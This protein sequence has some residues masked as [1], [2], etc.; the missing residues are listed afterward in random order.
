M[1]LIVVA[2]GTGWTI[3]CVKFVRLDFKAPVKAEI[4]RGIGIFPPIGAVVG[5]LHIDDTPC[6]NRPPVAKFEVVP[7][8]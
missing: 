5:W 6:K 1:F 4:I 2:L 3:N 8:N 7:V